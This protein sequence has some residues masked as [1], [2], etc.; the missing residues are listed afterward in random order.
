MTTFP[1]SYFVTFDNVKLK[2][3]F[4]LFV[5]FQK[6]VFIVKYEGINRNNFIIKYNFIY[7]DGNEKRHFQWEGRRRMIWSLLLVL[8]S[9][10][11]CI[12]AFVYTACICIKI[13]LSRKQISGNFQHVKEICTA[14]I[15]NYWFTVYR[16]HI[17][18]YT[19]TFKHRWY[20]AVCIEYVP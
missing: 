9:M 5:L 12:V 19:H 7:S 8:S 13:V 3:W 2:P 18:T 4:I 20:G 17:H 1:I 10:H 15:E 11:W 16:T 14:R 6:N